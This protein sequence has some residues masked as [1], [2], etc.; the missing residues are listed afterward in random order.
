MRRAEPILGSALRI[1]S[2][3]LA[4]A[5]W[6]LGRFIREHPQMGGIRQ[7]HADTLPRE[8]LRDG[9]TAHGKLFVNQTLSMRFRRRGSIPPSD[10]RTDL[11]D[12]M[13]NVLAQ[14]SMGHTIPFGI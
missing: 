11:D 6:Q 13:D 9:L 12:F 14:S 8:V 10:P 3:A 2:A 4:L 1:T 7:Y 5:Q